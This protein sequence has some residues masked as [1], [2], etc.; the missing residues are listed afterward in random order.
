METLIHIP[1][2]SVEILTSKKFLE[3]ANGAYAF[4]HS[5]ENRLYMSTGPLPHS[6]AQEYFKKLFPQGDDEIDAFY[7]TEVLPRLSGHGDIEK[8]EADSLWELA[9]CSGEC[10]IASNH[11][12]VFTTH[13]EIPGS[14]GSKER[15][16][17]SYRHGTYQVLMASIFGFE[18]WPDEEKWVYNH[19]ESERSDAQIGVGYIHGLKKKGM[20]E[21]FL[22]EAGRRMLF[23][24]WSEQPL[25]FRNENYSP[26]IKPKFLEQLLQD[27]SESEQQ[28]ATQ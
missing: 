16:L 5:K 15:N 9:V 22:Q 6:I 11:N 24:L 27:N 3:M 19:S 26:V 7:K 14:E 8:N 25:L 23:K 20:P 1:K 10:S 12:W 4:L 28:Q 21:L 13:V 17:K 2:P 18:Y